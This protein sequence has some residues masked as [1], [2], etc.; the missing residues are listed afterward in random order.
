MNMM[1]MGIMKINIVI[2]AL[3]KIRVNKYYLIK[4][5]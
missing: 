2:I 5:N 4:L 1:N 3:I